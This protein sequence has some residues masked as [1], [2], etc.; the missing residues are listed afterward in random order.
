MSTG[1]HRVCSTRQDG[2]YY[3][4][5]DSELIRI[6][7]LYWT[8]ELTKKL[9]NMEILVSS[10]DL[11]HISSHRGNHMGNFYHQRTD[12]EFWSRYA[13]NLLTNRGTISQLVS[14][15]LSLALKSTTLR[16]H[17]HLAVPAL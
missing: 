6:T 14:F 12:V 8:I 10:P 1:S 2:K 4:V 17:P 13:V 5:S 16:M 3:V 9:V 15:V 7:D 11:C